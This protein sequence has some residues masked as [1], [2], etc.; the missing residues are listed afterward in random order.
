MSNSDSDNGSGNVQLSEEEIIRDVEGRCYKAFQ[1]Y[2]NKGSG[3]RIR[4]EQLHDV[5]NHM[6]IT[7]SEQEIYK[8]ISDIDPENTGEIPYD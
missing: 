3:G 2:D 8:I 4:S 5:L 1:E 6:S 7:M